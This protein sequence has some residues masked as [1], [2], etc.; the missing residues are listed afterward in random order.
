MQVDLKL[1][2]STSPIYAPIKRVSIPAVTTS[3]K[4]Q[5]H[6]TTAKLALSKLNIQTNCG[7]VISL[8]KPYVQVKKFQSTNWRT[9][10]NV[11]I[12]IESIHVDTKMFE[13]FEPLRKFLK[14]PKL[15]V[16][17][18]NKMT[19]NSLR[20]SSVNVNIHFSDI[21]SKGEFFGEFT[22]QYEKLR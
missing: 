9:L 12:E 14:H 6:T 11:D 18:E 19:I 2:T 10:E 17:A 3:I 16:D 1:M 4:L 20:T 8:E 5:E 22:K 21:F 13:H 15:T 7:K